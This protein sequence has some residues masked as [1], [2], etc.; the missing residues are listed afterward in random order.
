MQNIITRGLGL[1]QSIIVKG[2]GGIFH[3]IKTLISNAYI[4]IIRKKIP[5]PGII[6]GL[7]RGGHINITDGRKNK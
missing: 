3:W 1:N 4:L 5:V 6:E 7:Q 2:F